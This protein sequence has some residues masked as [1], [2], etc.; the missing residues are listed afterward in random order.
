MRIHS[1]HSAKAVEPAPGLVRRTLAN[2][3][4]GMVCHFE[5]KKGAVIP[6]HSHRAVQIGFV[7]EGRVAFIGERPEDAFEAANGDSYAFDAYQFHGATILEDAKVLE[8]FT[9]TRVEYLDS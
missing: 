7:L 2:N 3:A 5:L 1:L 9:P 6:L 4:E 8:F